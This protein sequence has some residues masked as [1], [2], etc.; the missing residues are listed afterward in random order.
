MPVEIPV[1]ENIADDAPDLKTQ[2][3][4]FVLTGGLSAV[5]DFGLHSI[6]FY[7]VGLPINVSKSISFVA[8]TTTAY[9]INRR[10]TFKAEPSRA[11]F[12]AV[13]ALYALTFAVQV[14]LNGWLYDVFPDQWWRFPLAFVIAQGTATVINFVV[15]RAVIFKIR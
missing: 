1:T 10:W 15:Q 3:V 6:L 4:R 11:R 13:V 7:L 8:G 12:L 9:L 5:V 14:G 2:I